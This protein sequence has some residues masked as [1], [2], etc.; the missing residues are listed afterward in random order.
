MRAIWGYIRFGRK[1]NIKLTETMNGYGK[2]KKNKEQKKWQQV[3][4]IY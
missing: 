4:L 3:K 1:I 2:N